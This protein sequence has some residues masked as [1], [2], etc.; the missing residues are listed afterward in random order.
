MYEKANKGWTKHWDFILLDIL[1]L[2]VAFLFAFLTRFGNLSI[3]ESEIHQALFIL[4][5]FV[6]FVVLLLFGRFSAVL[7]R[8]PWIEFTQ[9]VR[10]CFYLF[11]TIAIILFS[12][13]VG[14]NFSRVFMYCYIGYYFALSLISRIVLKKILQKNRDKIAKKSLILI[15]TKEN[16][17]EIINKIKDNNY[18]GYVVSAIALK[19]F[20]GDTLNGMPVLK[21]KEQI[22]SFALNNWVDEV[23]FEMGAGV[24]V[25]P[26]VINRLETMGIAI[27][28]ASPI[29]ADYGYKVIAEQFAKIPVLTITSNVMTAKQKA[30][31]RILDICGGI[32]GSLITLILIVILGPIIKIKSPGPIFFKQTRI[33]KNGKTFKVI[34]F[35]SMYMDAEERKKNLMAQN[36]IKDG[37]MFKMEFDPR[38][39]GN[40]ID[41]NG[42]K[43]TG[44]GE[45]IRKYSLDEFPQFFNVLAG[46]MSL[47]GTRPPTMD[48]Y[49]KYQEH[50][51][52]RLAIKPGITG[53]WQVSG[54]SNIIDFEEVV[55]LDTQY[56][57]D[58]NLGE[59][60]KI[61]LKTVKMVLKR[62]GAM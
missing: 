58:W 17:E 34:K 39:I 32:V 3:F 14:S 29:P 36:R 41:E 16:Y 33:G 52:A 35:R 49:V 12:L 47:V 56:I 55:K 10:H 4:A 2:E 31:K 1:S 54:R 60:I 6:D 28:I 44:I 40:F 25:D 57:N 30:E 8:G 45:F 27:H 21:S 62:D 11:A 23:L 37:M 20:D 24:A 18:Q 26:M 19:D 50:H 38:V 13:K 7:R 5:P 48:E 9:T 53:M 43:H 61:I 51:K 59:D 15:A 46:D 22:M 42:N